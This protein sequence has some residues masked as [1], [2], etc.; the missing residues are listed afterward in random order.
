MHER[1]VRMAKM[2]RES[3]MQCAK[4]F[5]HCA[6][7]AMPWTIT[8]MHCAARGKFLKRET[9]QNMIGGASKAMRADLSLSFV[10]W[11]K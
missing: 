9:V 10:R 6:Y 4:V 8:S 11:L 5:M 7:S 2:G 3:A 1:K